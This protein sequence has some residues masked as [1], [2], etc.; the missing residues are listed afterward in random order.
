MT[1]QEVTRTG[2]TKKT[3]KHYLINA[4]AIYTNLKWNKTS[5]KWEGERLGATSD[6]NKLTIEL[7]YRT[8]EVD[9]VY[10]DAKGQKLLQKQTAK[11]ETNVKELTA[12]NIKLAINGSLETGDGETA[13]ADYKVISGKGKLEDSDYIENIGIVG[14]VSGS[15]NPIIVILDNALCTSGLDAEFKDDDEAVVAMTFEAHADADQVADLTL[16]CRIYY[17]TIS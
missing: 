14:T 17:P 7:T 4:G 15:D 16:P 8:V 2:Y 5:Q 12:E 9:G 10:T 3:P 6:G 11:L 13:P 1:K